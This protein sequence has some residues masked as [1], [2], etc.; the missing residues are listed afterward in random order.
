VEDIRSLPGG[1]L[2]DTPLHVHRLVMDRLRAM[3]P[4]E[5]L[6]EAAAMTEAAD[7]MARAGIRLQYPD[8]DDETV[9]LH[10]AIRKHGRELIGRWRQLPPE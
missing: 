4:S 9:D 2:S 10:L 3:T 1:E 8:A 6:L 7:R 5:R